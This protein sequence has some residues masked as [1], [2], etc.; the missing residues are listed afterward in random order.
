MSDQSDTTG[1]ADSPTPA[2]QAI[3]HAGRG[4]N[5]PPPEHRWRPGESGN[6][7]GRPT[8]GL[9]IRE[10]VNELA[11]QDLTEAELRKIARNPET[12]WTKRAAAERI[13][14]TLEHGDISDF[15]GVLR[16]ENNI[17]DLRAMGVNTEVVKKLK[18]KSRKQKVED[19]E[20]EEIIEREIELHDRAGQDF[21]RVVNHTAGNPVQPIEAE[22]KGDLNITQDVTDE[23]LNRVDQIVIGAKARGGQSA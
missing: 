11:R 23:D 17:E 16:G 12:G 10:H 22:V 20:V 13:L 4:G 18:T 3:A 1:P 21:D 2:D 19:G 9:T 6:P 14:R 8:A 5:I 15:A 7:A